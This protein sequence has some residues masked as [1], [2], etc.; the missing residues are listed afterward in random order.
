M[1][2]KGWVRAI[3]SWVLFIVALCTFVRF[4]VT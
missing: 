1:S 2:K 4:V 3:A